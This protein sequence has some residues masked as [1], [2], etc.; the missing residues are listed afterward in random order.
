ML[1]RSHIVGLSVLAVAAA[2]LGAYVAF[3]AVF[4]RPRTIVTGIA[5]VGGPFTLTA[6]TGERISDNAFRGQFML[7]AFGFTHCPDVC[8]AE[9]QIMTAALE[10]MG[11][12]AERV[13]PL[14]IT[15]DP[16][17]DTAEHLADYL[18]HFHPRLIGLTGT[19]EEIAEVAGAYRV[20]Y[21]KVQ[22]DAA[23]YVMDHTSITYLMGP[24]G[25]FVQ[26]FS[27]GTSA[28]T[29]AKAL[30]NAVNS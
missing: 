7:V 13:Q 17:R 6:H 15:I 12:G 10:S 28:D 29:L 26:H 2:I 25:A 20:W 18:V 11:E 14:F 27:F 21:E 19:T 22:L 24:D 16:E 1:R 30:N 23:D 5:D 9:L 4:D 8:P 3:P